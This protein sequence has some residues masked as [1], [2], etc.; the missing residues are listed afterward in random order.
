MK[1]ILVFLFLFSFSYAQDDKDL[2]APSTS[3]WKIDDQ[4]HSVIRDRIFH[5]SINKECYPLEEKNCD[6]KKALDKYLAI[7]LTDEIKNLFNENASVRPGKIVCT[8]LLSGQVVLGE[9]PIRGKFPK[10][11]E[12]CQF[13]DASFIT[14]SSLALYQG[15]QKLPE[16]DQDLSDLTQE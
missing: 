14:I 15:P 10:Y 13:E 12:F 4:Y 2:L 8:D 7:E 6:V 5:I 9:K 1:H 11:E 16:I 3:R